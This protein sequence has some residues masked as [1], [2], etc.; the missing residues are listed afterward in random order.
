MNIIYEL[1]T[2]LKGRKEKGVISK[3]YISKFI[4]NSPVI[5]EAGAH[6]GTD[7]SEMARLW[8]SA[9]IYAF[10]PIPEIFSQ[11]KEN[12]SLYDNVKCYEVALGSYT[13]KCEIFKS[14]GS[15]DGSSSVLAP[16]EHLI[17][18]P[19][20]EFNTK[21]IVDII[22]LKDFFRKE[23]ID[24]VDL[25]WLDLQGF[26]LEVL[27]VADNLLENVSAVYTEVS[28]VENYAGS[29]LYEDLKKWMRGKGY[30]V[31]K[32]ELAWVDGGNVLFVKK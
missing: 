19:D 3:R 9:T 29:V 17:Y 12:T 11:L 16:K 22:T 1:L 31:K 2:L 8:P 4:H 10:E 20:V 28:L 25:L 15:S 30:K 23:K 18:H 24:K 27:K 26:E 7:T 14:S 13:G 32:E 21:V 6:I 5:I